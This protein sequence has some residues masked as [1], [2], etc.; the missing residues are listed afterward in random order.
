MT[1]RKEQIEKTEAKLKA[2]KAQERAKAA[3]ERG[4]A[5]K[6]RRNALIQIGALVCKELDTDWREFMPDVFAVQLKSCAAGKWV[7]EDG[8]KYPMFDCKRP[9]RLSP[10]EAREMWRDFSK[11]HNK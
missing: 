10:G 5:E 2:L 4:Q 11:K 8:S 6:W 9:D 3:R 7:R 1:T